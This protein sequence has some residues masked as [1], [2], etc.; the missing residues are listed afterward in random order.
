MGVQCG[1]GEKAVGWGGH[2]RP[3]RLLWHIGLA[4][5]YEVWSGLRGGP[6]GL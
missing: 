3:E 5:I 4:G 6:D 2:Q 1:T